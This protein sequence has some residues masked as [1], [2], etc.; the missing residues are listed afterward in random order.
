MKRE[1][2]NAENATRQ[3]RDRDE[4]DRQNELLFG[5]LGGN[6]KRT[7]PKTAEDFSNKPRSNKIGK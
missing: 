7:F 5:F 3:R 4:T 2:K 1:N 6:L